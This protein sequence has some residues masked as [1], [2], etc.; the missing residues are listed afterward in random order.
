MNESMLLFAVIICVFIITRYVFNES[1]IPWVLLSAG[2]GLAV[3][4]HKSNN[5]VLDYW[6]L[7]VLIPVIVIAEKLLSEKK[8]RV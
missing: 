2:S 7:S 3:F 4:Y 1:I 8:M 6:E 5:I